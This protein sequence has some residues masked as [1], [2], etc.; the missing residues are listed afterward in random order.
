M[1]KLRSKILE[2]LSEEK[3]EKLQK[4][5]EKMID[6]RKIVCRNLR[7]EIEEKLK[8]AIEQKTNGLKVIEKQF[9]QIKENQNTILELTGIIKVLTQL[10]EPEIKEEMKKE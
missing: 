10:L 4:T 1:A 3:K 6:T 7:K 2:N 9:A 8:W 5:L